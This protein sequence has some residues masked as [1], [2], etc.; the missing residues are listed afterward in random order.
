MRRWKRQGETFIL[1]Q[2]LAL[3]L[4]FFPT[5]ARGENP[6]TPPVQPPTGTLTTEA[7][8]ATGEAAP[9]LEAILK[10]VLAH[11]GQ[12]QES[13]Q[14]VEVARAQVAQARAAAFPRGA[15][16]FLAAPIFEER[17]DAL[18]SVANYG[19]WGP[20]LQGG[21]QIIQP[22]YTFGQISGYQKAAAAQ[23]EA[24]DGLA[25]VKRWEVLVSAKDFYYSYLMAHDLY[26]LV[27]DLSSFLEEAI[28]TAEKQ[29][30]GSKKSSIKPHDV[31]RLK[32]A[33]QDLLQKKYV[34]ESG[35][36]TAERA[37]LWVSGGTFG[38]VPTETLKPEAY[39][40][41]SL[42]EYL[43][44][45]RRNRPEFR[46]LA[47]GQE[48]RNALADAKRAQSYP[49]LFLGA[50]GQAM[51]SPVRDHQISAY[52]NDPFNNLLGGAGVGFKLDIEFWRHAAESAEQRAEAM[53][54]KAT[55]SYAA[56]G[57]ELQVKKAFWE[58]E[59]AREGLKIAT[60]RKDL[61]RK[62]FVSNGM[63]WSVGLTPAKDLIEALEGNGLAR[64]NYVE[65][66]YQYNMALAK[67]SQAV[68]QEVTELK[69]RN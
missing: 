62:W 10:A 43:A 31:Y 20:F 54:L 51:W 46:A 7:Q 68:G 57:I 50:F 63:G 30:S 38:S 40:P 64:K 2:S 53:K 41:K 19:K 23:V 36:K 33:F 4:Y 56:P 17:G 9:G 37:I 5:L 16:M 47:A 6:A 55:E 14:D 45:A 49:V 13:L 28:K 15:V 34:A 42:D 39:T 27:D 18:K 59:Q 61:G 12:I 69:Y 24:K 11:N 3:A 44:I 35:K 25:E 60:D 52:A 26:K 21:L 67:L 65:T 32:T 48:A 29:T 1:A 8:S 58:M 66:V 22:L